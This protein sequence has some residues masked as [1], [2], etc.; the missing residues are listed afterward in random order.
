MA[1]RP[2]HEISDTA[3]SRRHRDGSTRQLAATLFLHPL[4][5]RTGLRVEGEINVMNRDYWARELSGL[6]GNESDVDLEMSGLVFIDA[7]GVAVLV[8]A[9]ARSQA[10]SRMRGR[11][12]AS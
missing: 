6:V 7:G 1:E 4:P 8:R 12:P 10:N 5:H 11:A 2:R 9:A 3:W